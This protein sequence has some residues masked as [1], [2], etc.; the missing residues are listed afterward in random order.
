MPT[1]VTLLGILLAALAGVLIIVWWLRHSPR[2]LD[3]VVAAVPLA[4]ALSYLSSFIFR[5]PDYKAG[6]E[7]LCPGWWGYPIATHLSDGAGVGILNPGGFILNAVVYYI[8]LL[9]F[10]GIVVWLAGQLHWSER[11]WRWRFVFLLL[12]VALPLAFLPTWFPPKVPQFPTEEQRLVNNAARAW[13]WQLQFRRWTDRRLAVEDVRPHPD[14]ER[15]RVC[16]R[17]YT[18]FYIPYDKVYIDLEPE[19]VRATG[20]GVIDLSESCWVQP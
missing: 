10:S 7:G 15:H 11:R 17:V 4:F 19:G 16:F 20:G 8:L 13:R 6:C 1:L 14:G 18:W 3:W 5:V 2:G 12:T 9:L